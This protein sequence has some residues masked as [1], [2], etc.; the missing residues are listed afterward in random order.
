MPT[1]A[2]TNLTISTLLDLTAASAHPALP[3][4]DGSAF[5][6]L[7]QS[8]PKLERSPHPPPDAERT[9]SA[10][11]RP[12][13]SRT[14]GEQPPYPSAS[15]EEQTETT[16]TPSDPSTEFDDQQQEEVTSTT[17]AIA[18]AETL[19]EQS[20]AA[21]PLQPAV[22]ANAP[23]SD[24]DPAL[25][26][27]E[28]DE[29][30]SA[31]VGSQSKRKKAAAPAVAVAY[32]STNVAG[33]TG[34]SV[35]TAATTDVSSQEA[36]NTQKGELSAAQAT[37]PDPSISDLPPPTSDLDASTA[38]LAQEFAP[39]AD[40]ATSEAKTAQ[41][42][43]ATRD[44]SVERVAAAELATSASSHQASKDQ[45]Q[46]TV[47]PL[48]TPIATQAAAQQQQSPSTGRGLPQS[49]AAAGPANR[50]RLPGQLLAQSEG[51]AARRGVVEVDTTRLLSRVARAFAA[52]Q[53]RDGEIRLR[54]SPPEL[55]AL[56]LEVRIQDGVMVAHLET[57]TEAARTAIVENLPALRE[58]LAEQGVRIERFDVD[59]MQRQPSGTPNQS[60]GGQQESPAPVQ[61]PTTPVRRTTESPSSAPGSASAQATAGGLNV[62]I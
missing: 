21:I 19:I 1:A 36:G 17:D 40:A 9:E 33:A 12:D 8:P 6:A 47:T 61:R 2:P 27:S 14:D 42:E 52:A 62:I 58:R 55:G 29:Q 56:R 10:A 32:H 15:A 46:P 53:E 39:A 7:L 60:G 3:A 49:I 13:S 51:P 31:V 59:L 28:K 57:E 43:P 23:V 16:V 11:R 45:P 22:L 54:L 37:E 38:G 48:A 5:D 41:N 20:L 34:A 18:A 4:D 44:V 25:E 30:E 26:K 35:V 50:T 24:S